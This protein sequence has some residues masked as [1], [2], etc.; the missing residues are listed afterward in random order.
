MNK[1]RSF[2]APAFTLLELLTV[3]AVITIL[4]MLVT[5]MIRSALESSWEA[6]ASHQARQIVAALISDASD[7]GTFYSKEDIGFSSYRTVDD[8]LGLPRLME[9]SGYLK[10]KA[11]WWAPGSRRELKKFGNSFAWNRND[12]VCG[13][14]VVAMPEPSSVALFWDNYCYTLPSSI[15]VREPATGGPRLPAQNYWYYPYRNNRA[16]N[17]AYA[18]G[19]V[20]LV[21]KIE[22]NTPTPAPSSSLAAQQAA[23]N[24][25]NSSGSGSTSGSS[26]GTPSTGSGVT[27]PGDTV[28]GQPMNT[29]APLR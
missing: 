7:R 13:K 12:S 17:F 9:R 1:S 3:M 24:A 27:D 18:D 20:G 5:H 19:H 10:D 28:N 4:A 26:S 15:G 16:A 14:S 22:K 25:S 21:Y 2:A 29:P 8:P 11:A 23:A 6:K